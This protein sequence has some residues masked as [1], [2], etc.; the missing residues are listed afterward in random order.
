MCFNLSI[1]SKEIG[2]TSKRQFYV[3]RS[4]RV[5]K[6]GAMRVSCKNGSRERMGAQGY[7]A[8]LRKGEFRNH[9]SCQET[10]KS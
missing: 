6:A 9:V 4:V 1:S 5:G 7:A 2:E 8:R 3:S 10:H